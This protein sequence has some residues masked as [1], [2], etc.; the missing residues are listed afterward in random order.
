MRLNNRLP[1]QWY[2]P[3]ASNPYHHRTRNSF[4]W[5]MRNPPTFADLLPEMQE[6]ARDQVQEF[7][8]L[9]PEKLRLAAKNEAHYQEL[10]SAFYRNQQVVEEKKLAQAVSDVIELAREG[11]YPD[12]EIFHVPASTTPAMI[13]VAPP[14]EAPPP[15][16]PSI[17]EPPPIPPQTL[18][19]L[20]QAQRALLD[21]VLQEIPVV[22]AEMAQEGL[23]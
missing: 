7:L 12:H 13:D 11:G 1:N 2:D 16:M 5:R 19:G 17:S 8:R 3:R 10:L 15:M 6:A 20:D 14:Y 23:I 21:A 9:V 22:V 4:A 18:E